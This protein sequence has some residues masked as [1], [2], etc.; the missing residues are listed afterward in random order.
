MPAAGYRGYNDKPVSQVGSYGGYWSSSP[1]ERRAHGA[2]TLYF[3]S[4]NIYPQESY[5]RSNGRTVRCAKNSPNSETL[6]L[7]AN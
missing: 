6:T 4:S 1:D 7:H 2:L 3:M 5:Y